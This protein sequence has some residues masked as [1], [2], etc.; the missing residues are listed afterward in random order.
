L[1]SLTFFFAP[2]SKEHRAA[3]NRRIIDPGILLTDGGVDIHVPDFAPGFAPQRRRLYE[4][5]IKARL[6]E[7]FVGGNLARREGRPWS[8]S[9]IATVFSLTVADPG[10]ADR[11]AYS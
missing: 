2:G 5:Q 1:D 4:E 3:S 11:L 7:T 10:V 6:E 9:W 8:S